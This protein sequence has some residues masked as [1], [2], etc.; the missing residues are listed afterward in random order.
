[1]KQPNDI[2]EPPKAPA[3][4]QGGEPGGVDDELMAQFRAWDQAGKEG[5]VQ[6]GPGG[7]F[8]AVG[9]EELD[10]QVAWARA[11]R[12]RWMRQSVMLL[13]LALS[14]LA[15]WSG[16]VE[17]QYLFSSG[18]PVELGS[19]VDQFLEAPERREL[20]SNQ[21]AHASGLV[22]TSESEAGRY[23][24]FYCPLYQLVVRT[25]RELPDQPLS[26]AAHIEVDAKFAPLLESRLVFPHD[27]TE[28][29]E[30]EGRL[31][32]FADAPRWARPALQ[33]YAPLIEGRPEDAY[34]LVDGDAPSSFVWYGVGLFAALAISGVSVWLWW[35]ARRLER[36]LAARAFS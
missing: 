7:I 34:L 35:R 24:Y 4:A 18:E 31:I 30:A 5:H 26:T 12:V 21:F 16:R 8:V 2:I 32:R 6:R 27:L 23:R 25:E 3:E 1:M 15:I 14:G 11:R 29:F 13:L 22:M 20:P 10:P 19:I 28:F 17:L 36:V 9:A 33:F